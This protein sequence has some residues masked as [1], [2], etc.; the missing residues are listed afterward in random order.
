M[1]KF[2]ALERVK[3]NRKAIDHE[4][5]FQDAFQGFER[6]GAIKSI[7]GNR[8]VNV[9]SSLKIKFSDKPWYMWIDDDNG[10]LMLGKKYMRTGRKLYLYLD[11][12]H[13]LTHIRQHHEG[14][15]L[16]DEKYEYV[17]RPTE[18]EAYRNAV[19]EAK[20]LGMSEKEIRS[21]LYMSWFTKPQFDRLLKHCGL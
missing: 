9:L 8:T 1:T 13:E 21:Y 10:R 7:F 5:A 14:R 19:N 3:I 12:V 18:I 6:V 4:C 17:D 11:V 15:E 2:P 16:F 20:R